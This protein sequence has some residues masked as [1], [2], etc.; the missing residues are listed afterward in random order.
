MTLA[1]IL[2]KEQ[3]VAD[4]KATNR[5]EAIDELLDLLVQCGKIKSENREAIAAVVR[6]R[7]NSMSTGIGFGIGARVGIGIVVVIAIVIFPVLVAAAVSVWVVLQASVAAPI[8]V[9]VSISNLLTQAHR[10]SHSP[11]SPR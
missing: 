4:L 5:W 7:E 9:L 6:K 8:S 10:T 3:I 2:R 11:L 1:D